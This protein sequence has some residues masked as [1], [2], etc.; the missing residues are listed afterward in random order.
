VIPRRWPGSESPRTLEVVRRA[1]AFDTAA[2]V[3]RGALNRQMAAFLHA[4]VI[5]RLNVVV[6]GAGSSGKT[7]VLGA[8]AALVPETQRLVVLEDT[9]E[10]RIRH[11]NVAYL[12]AR[13]T[14]PLSDLVRASLRMRPDRLVVGEVRGG[15]AAD[16]LGVL[17]ARRLTA[18]GSL[19]KPVLLPYLPSR[20]VSTPRFSDLT[21]RM[22]SLESGS[23]KASIPES[24]G[25]KH[26]TSDGMTA[27]RPP[28]GSRRI[29]TT[30]RVEFSLTKLPGSPR[31]CLF[32]SPG[33]ENCA[34]PAVMAARLAHTDLS[35]AT[36]RST[37][38]TRRQP[39]FGNKS[40]TAGTCL[41]PEPTRT[42]LGSLTRRSSEGD[43]PYA[44]DGIVTRH[45]GYTVLTL[46]AR[47]SDGAC[48]MHYSSSS[49]GSVF[50]LTDDLPS[51]RNLLFILFLS[52][53]REL[54]C[55]FL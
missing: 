49:S 29:D 11:P 52:Q 18:L 39:C 37:V 31:R 3:G 40:A 16:R 21:Y 47:R 22:L 42:E 34:L 2:L 6:T 15:E 27:W 36:L 24:K 32:S 14:T 4:G 1:E 9:H 38:R 7:T 46:A 54:P 10:L 50:A 45:A 48:C 44:I 5:G 55:R 17:M 26:G 12:E 23:N 25:N 53:R 41:L 51:W 35:S 13:P 28:S 8:L 19:R 20:S 30:G 43:S 33:S